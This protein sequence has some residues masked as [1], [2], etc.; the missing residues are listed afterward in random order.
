MLEQVANKDSILIITLSR[1]VAHSIERSDCCRRAGVHRPPF[2]GHIFMF[3][4][5]EHLISPFVTGY[6]Y[7]HRKPW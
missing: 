3:G 6:E 2:Y 1:V 5:S 7:G 4:L